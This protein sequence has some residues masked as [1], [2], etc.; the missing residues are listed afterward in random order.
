MPRRSPAGWGHIAGN[1]AALVDRQIAELKEQCLALVGT[2]EDVVIG[3]LRVDRFDPVN[4]WLELRPNS[5]EYSSPGGETGFAS[6]CPP[7][8]KKP[9][10]VL[11]THQCSAGRGL[12]PGSA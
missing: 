10:W 2:Q 6:Q 4:S 5:F 11:R 9:R 1:F 8:M 3:P 12:D 7:W